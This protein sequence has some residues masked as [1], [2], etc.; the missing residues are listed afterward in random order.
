MFYLSSALSRRRSVRRAFTLIELLVVIAI[1]AILAAILFPVF[2]KARE[3]A[4]QTACLSNMKQI[5]L[6]LMM[7]V[8]D[9]DETMPYPFPNN[10]GING[11]SNCGQ[12][13]DQL[14]TPYT[15]SDAIWACPDDST[16]FG[17]GGVPPF[18]NGNFNGSTTASKYQHRTYSYCNT[19]Y[20]SHPLAGGT[21]PDAN[22]GM[23]IWD[24]GIPS[25][26]STVRS[27]ARIDAPASTIAVVETANGTTSSDEGS[28]YGSIFGNCDA[29]KLPGRTYGDA[30]RTPSNGNCNSYFATG[31]P[32]V[33]HT[34]MGNYVFGDGHVKSLQWN[35]VSAN[36]Y[37][38]FKLTK[39]TGTPYTP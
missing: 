25:T 34:N 13:I 38:L 14:L 19:I 33:G 3:K 26:G 1:I 28:P 29:Y 39:N 5:G 2:A 16:A 21:G 9:Y 31:I 15:K 12:P 4:R 22:T 18:W 35:Y 30:S 24:S 17:V 20:T 32:Y 8:Q 10:P 23:C 36:D 11:G 27:I 37:D 7:Y 6:G